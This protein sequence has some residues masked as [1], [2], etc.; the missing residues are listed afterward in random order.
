LCHK[1]LRA[2]VGVSRWDVSGLLNQTVI[3]VDEK[4][5]TLGDFYA[6]LR[7]AKNDVFR[8]EYSGEI[9]PQYPDEPMPDRCIGSSA[10]EAR[11][12]VEQMVLGLGYARLLWDELP[13]RGL[14]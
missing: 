10:T 13:W 11:I 7:E 6:S 12:W 8:G 1:F 14:K 4:Q 2:D 3:A 9:N 5:Q